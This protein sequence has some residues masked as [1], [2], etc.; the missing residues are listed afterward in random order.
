MANLTIFFPFVE[1]IAEKKIDLSSDTLKIALSD[2]APSNSNGVIGDITEINYANCSSRIISVIS[3]EQTS[4]VYSLKVSNVTISAS[5]G[6]IASFRY[7]IIYDNTSGDLIG[8]YDYGSSLTI[9]DGQSLLISFSDSL[10]E[11]S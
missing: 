5:G 3:S 10:I 6:S 9:A 2:N 1:K 4:G 11:I 8:Y 7:I